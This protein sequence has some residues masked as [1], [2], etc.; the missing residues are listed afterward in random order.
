MDFG[1]S[2]APGAPK[3]GGIERFVE[4]FREKGDDVDA[5][6]QEFSTISTAR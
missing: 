3:D 6:G 5:H 2:A 4:D 1:L